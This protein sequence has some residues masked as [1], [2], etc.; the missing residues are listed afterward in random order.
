MPADEQGMQPQAPQN[1]KEFGAFELFILEY[2]VFEQK[3]AG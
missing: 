1:S 2:D 3:R